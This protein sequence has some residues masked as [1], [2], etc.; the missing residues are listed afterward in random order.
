MIGMLLRVLLLPPSLANPTS[1]VGPTSRGAAAAGTTTLPHCNITRWNALCPALP[2]QPAK[3]FACCEAH[4][5]ELVAMQCEGPLP[6]WNYSWSDHCAGEPPPP[7]LHPGA[8]G[9][10]GPQNTTFQCASNYGGLNHPCPSVTQPLCYGFVANKAWGHCCAGHVPGP[11]APPP[12]GPF[13]LSRLGASKTFDGL[14]AI[15]GGGATSRLLVD[16]PL[17]QREQILDYL[18]KPSFGAN[19]QI[20]KV[21][22]GG[23]QDTTDGCESSHMHDNATVDLNAGYEWWLM[24]AAKKRNP[25]IKLY[26]LPWAFPG[27][28]A[29][30]PLSGAR[31]DSG[32][33][34]DHPEQTCR[35]ILEWVRGARAAH[36][37][38]IDYLGVWNEAP[39]NANY[40]KLLRKTLDSNGFENT[41]IVGHDANWDI[42]SDMLKDPEYMDAVGVIGL[43]YPSDFNPPSV[44]EPCHATG[45]PIWA[46]EESSSH[47]DMNGAACWARVT[48]A[49][50]V[51]NGFTA[52]IMWNMLGSYY[53]GTAFYATSLMTA[54]QPWSGHYG[55]DDEGRSSMP[56]L[57]ANAH[58]TQF[59]QIGWKYL[60]VGRGSGELP[61]GGYFTTIVD[62]SA[63]DGDF[64]LLVVKISYD[65]AACIRPALPSFLANVTEEEVT[66]VLDASM[67]KFVDLTELNC[68][69]SNFQDGP[70]SPMFEK[71]PP[72]SVVNGR[73]T[74]LVRPGD[75]FSVS[76]VMTAHKGSFDHVPR[77]QPRFP[78]PLSDDFDTAVVSSQPKFWS[79]ELVRH[80]WKAAA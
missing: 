19:L 48:N 67:G 71:Q 3:C 65:H 76:T 78:L 54:D 38:D 28:V 31:N 60:A 33:P 17:T 32:S 57:W 10:T 45:K 4:K 13:T 1:P 37:L 70:A 9:C 36:N 35:Y 80:S 30:D 51:L 23:D 41:V 61:A 59:T 6:D 16:Y 14:G 43:H 42:C 74:L 79:N 58:V 22:I 29:N 15:S 50:F 20:L 56:V 62:T 55:D 68:F 27:W 47:D 11:P 24:K 66:F 7:Y 40:V 72:V 21:E 5:A 2:S 53:Y 73:F 52:S 44:Y 26:G 49:H 25:A 69:K 64:T 77:S 75:Y 12:P 46:S 34:Y 18:F 8:T 39:S 63:N